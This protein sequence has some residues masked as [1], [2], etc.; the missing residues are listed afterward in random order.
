MGGLHSLFEDQVIHQ[1]LRCGPLQKSGLWKIGLAACQKF[2]AKRC[3]I[4]VR[5]MNI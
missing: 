3:I 1:E 5:A 2:Y 4:S